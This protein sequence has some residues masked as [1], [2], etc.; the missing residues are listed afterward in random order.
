[1]CSS[2]PTLLF[3]TYLVKIRFR[4]WVSVRD[5]TDIKTSQTPHFP[6]SHLSGHKMP[7]FQRVL[8]TQ[9]PSNKHYSALQSPSSGQSAFRQAPNHVAHKGFM[10]YKCSSSWRQNIPIV[11]SQQNPASDLVA[12]FFIIGGTCHCAHFCSLAFCCHFMVMVLS[13]VAYNTRSKYVYKRKNAFGQIVKNTTITFSCRSMQTTKTRSPNQDLPSVGF[14]FVFASSSIYGRVSENESLAI[15]LSGCVTCDFIQVQ[16]F[17]VFLIFMYKLMATLYVI[18][19][20]Q[21]LFTLYFFSTHSLFT[22][23]FAKDKYI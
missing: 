20:E 7:C 22:A 17:T 5:L 10:F 23:Y 1:M 14:Q 9:R 13:Q 11:P 8:M 12:V 6:Q 18:Y 16:M 21:Y 3:L 19:L 15:F 4:F 2:T